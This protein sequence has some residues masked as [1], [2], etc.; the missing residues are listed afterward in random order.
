MT[1]FPDDFHPRASAKLPDH[2]YHPTSGSIRT[3]WYNSK[4][5]TE[6]E[7]EEQPN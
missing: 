2:N 4:I 6:Y 5:R 1:D 3:E 7:Y